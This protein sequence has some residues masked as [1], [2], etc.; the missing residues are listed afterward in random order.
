MEALRRNIFASKNCLV[1]F[2]TSNHK[3]SHE[4]APNKEKGA[5]TYPVQSKGVRAAATQACSFYSIASEIF[6]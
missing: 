3:F 6:L 2:W 4:I 1:S 5:L